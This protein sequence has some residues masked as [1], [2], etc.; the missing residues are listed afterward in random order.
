MVPDE[1]HRNGNRIHYLRRVKKLEFVVI[2]FSS[3]FLC[4][5]NNVVLVQRLFT[6]NQPN[7]V[8]Q[9]HRERLGTFKNC[10]YCTVT[11]THRSLV[12]Y[13]LVYCITLDLLYH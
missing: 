11:D 7:A 6:L 12:L 3:V 4:S 1:Y 2:W 8:H 10:L 13:M 9:G 5:K